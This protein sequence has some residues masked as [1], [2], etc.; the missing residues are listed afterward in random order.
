MKVWLSGASALLLAVGVHA[1]VQD[2]ENMSPEELA[3]MAASSE[4]RP[5]PGQYRTEITLQSIDMPGAPPQMA[6]MMRK[7]M[8]RT[9]QY[10]LTEQ[11]IE[12]GFRSMAQQ[13]QQGECTYQRFEMVGNRIDGQMTC[14]ADGRELTMTMEGT[15]APTSADMTMTVSGDFGMGDGS[16]TLRSVHNRIGGC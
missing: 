14:M 1:A 2:G 15:G 7:M 3:A 8:S 16:M 6:G 13:S 4:V 12:D 5:E 10:C 9:F 11:D